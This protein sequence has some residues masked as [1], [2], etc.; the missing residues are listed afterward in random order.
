VLSEMD[1]FDTV[2]IA[3]DYDIPKELEDIV[4]PVVPIP[5]DDPA[6]QTMRPVKAIV[7]IPIRFKLD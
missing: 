3:D 5:I 6:R 7:S 1:P 4:Q 2:K